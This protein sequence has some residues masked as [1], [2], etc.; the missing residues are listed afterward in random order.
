MTDDAAQ[1]RNGVLCAVAAFSL[2]GAFPI[3]FKV[4]TGVTA[5][6]MLAHRIAWAVPFGL[7]IVLMRRQWP[8]LRAIVRDRRTLAWL[9]LGSTVIAI[10]WLVYIFAVQE[11]QIFQASLG[12]YINPLLLVLAGFVFHGERLRPAQALAVIFAAAGVLVLAM[13]GGEWPWISL[14]LAVSFTIYGLVR[15]QVQVGAMPGL[16]IETLFLLPAALA[17]LVLLGG[18]AELA[19]VNGS[20]LLTWLLVLAGPLTVLPLLLFAI[21]ARRLR[22]STIGFLQFIGPTGQFLVGVAYGEPVTPAHAICFALIWAAVTIFC[23]DAWRA[24]PR[25]AAV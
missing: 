13:R 25:T 3:Y 12:Y 14:T 11:N 21:G 24:R 6:E 22:L 15:K 19:F 9:A 16:F 4:A 2:W 8:E 10:N 18:R 17:Y 7:V 23:V 20:T 5:L 1:R